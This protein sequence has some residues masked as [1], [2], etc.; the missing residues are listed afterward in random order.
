MLCPG[1]QN[2]ISVSGNLLFLSVDSSRSDDSCASTTQPA[3][4]KDVLGGHE[5]L[6]HQRPG[7]TRST[8]R[9]SRPP[10]ARTPTRWCPT[11]ASGTCT[12][13]SRRTPP[14]RRSPTASRRT[15]P[16]PSSRCRAGPPSG[17]SGRATPVLF[18]DGGNPGGAGNSRRRP[19]ATTSP[20][21]PSQATSPPA[22]A[23][24]T[25]SCSTS[26]TAEHPVVIERVQD[27][28]ELR[29]LALRDLQ[30]QRHTRWSSPTSSA[31]AARP[32]ATATIGP[33]RGADGIYD[34]VGGRAGLPQLLQDAPRPGRT[35]RTASPTTVR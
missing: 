30:Q 9:P 27:N 12:S 15:T 8:S 22:P 19:A 32:P 10:A 26:R 17:P 35:P 13:T 34:I 18:P 7:A 28:D 25:A 29:V 24:V 2:D 33:N 3:T 5:G 11:R 1:S 16:S 14:T 31:A 20:C 23:W 21:Y 6:R 4:E